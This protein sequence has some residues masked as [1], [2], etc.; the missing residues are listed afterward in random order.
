MEHEQLNLFGN[1][2]SLKDE[3][4]S[5]VNPKQKDKA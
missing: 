4:S 3:V 2:E 5:E 1:Q